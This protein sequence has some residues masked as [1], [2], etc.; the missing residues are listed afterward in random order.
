VVADMRVE[1]SGALG[2]FLRSQ[3]TLPLSF[4]RATAT[5][6]FYVVISPPAFLTAEAK[7]SSDDMHALAC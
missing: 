5:Q 6:Q 2:S 7:Q 3:L 4:V 1:F